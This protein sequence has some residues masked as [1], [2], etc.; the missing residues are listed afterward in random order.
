MDTFPQQTGF[1]FNEP[2]AFDASG[3][4]NLQFGNAATAS[5]SFTQ[6][7]LQLPPGT[8]KK[9]IALSFGIYGLMTTLQPT[10]GVS[11]QQGQGGQGESGRSSL[12]KL[13]NTIM[14]YSIIRFQ[15][16]LSCTV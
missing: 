3:G 8:A 4:D 16:G 13:A 10:D 9:P 6:G 15:L 2:P 14:H 1:N 11:Q 7:S 5:T 12:R